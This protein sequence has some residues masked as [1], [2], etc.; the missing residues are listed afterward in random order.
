MDAD[1]RAATDWAAEALTASAL[2]SR[3]ATFADA[4]LS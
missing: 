1:K 4:V 2:G 3:L